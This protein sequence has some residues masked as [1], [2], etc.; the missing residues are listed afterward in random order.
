VDEVDRVILDMFTTFNSSVAKTN[1]YC[2]RKSTMAFRLE[3]SKFFPG[4]TQFDVAPYGISMIL[5]NDFRGFHVR[6]MPVA[7]GGLRLIKSASPHARFTNHQSLF[8]ENYALAFT[9]NKKNKDIPEFGSK[10]TILLEPSNQSEDAG[11]F[12]FM[13]YISGMMDLL[14]PTPGEMLDHHGEEEIIFFGPDEGTAGYMDNAAYYA[15]ERKYRFWSAATTG[16]PPQMGGIPHDTYGMTTRSVHEF[17]LGALEKA[18]LDERDV[19]KLQTGGPDGDL[20]SNEILISKDK[21]IGI[22]DGSGVV[23]DPN[24]LHRD[25]LERLAEERVMAEHFDRSALSSDGAFVSVEDKNVALPDGTVVES[26]LAFRNEFHFNPLAKADLF[27]PCGGRPEA[28]NAM[29]VHRLINSDGDHQFKYIVEGANLFITEDARDV[30]EKAG[31]ILYKDASTNKGGVT[32]SSFEVLASLCMTDSEHESMMR[33]DQAGNTPDF[34]KQYVDEIISI[35]ETNARLEFE[36]VHRYAEATGTT[37]STTTDILSEK[38]N[39]LN[40]ACQ[41]SE[42]WEDMALRREVLTRALPRTLQAKL[43]LDVMIERLPEDYLKA[44]FGYYI[45]SRFVYE[46]GMDVDGFE[47]LTAFF[48]HMAQLT[49]DG[50]A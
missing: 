27:V 16:K 43:G 40:T 48:G 11:R 15:R 19:T 32:S 24:G 22:V 13:K 34:Y 39:M 23:F 17:V 42:L 38:I 36:A 21:T 8:K 30:L 28:I 45:A 49:K 47:Y 7:R 44:V 50:R 33:A 6:F 3:P 12:A 25:E 31:I 35:I 9:Q 37:R 4:L 2:D 10:G 5:S 14:L 46:R 26:G 29:N 20:G 18:G 1:F 41:Q